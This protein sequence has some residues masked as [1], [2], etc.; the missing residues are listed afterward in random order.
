MPSWIGL[1]TLN[2][3]TLKTIALLLYYPT[4]LS[5]IILKLQFDYVKP[6]G[7]KYFRTIA[8]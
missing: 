8:L 4:M 6:T 3:A 7:L 1:S 5:L 2:Y